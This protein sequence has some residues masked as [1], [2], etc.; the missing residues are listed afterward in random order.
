[1]R[2]SGPK[3]ISPKC[4]RGGL[5]QDLTVQFRMI[6][7]EGAG[8]LGVGVEA[9]GSA[10]VLRGRAAR[11]RAC[12]EHDRALRIPRPRASTPLDVDRLAGPWIGGGNDAVAARHQRNADSVAAAHRVHRRAAVEL[13]LVPGRRPRERVGDDHLA[14]RDVDQVTGG[15]PG[16]GVLRIK[17]ELLRLLV[18][19]SLRPRLAVVEERPQ[20][21]LVQRDQPRRKCRL[22]RREIGAPD[23]PQQLSQPLHSLSGN[24]H[25]IGNLPSLHPVVS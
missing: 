24:T 14:I 2:S 3:I 15:Q 5:V 8:V 9:D 6:A 20:H 10:R 25:R 13:N 18:K 17:A 11:I 19:P 12:H 7:Q 1:V 23:A 22:I 16:N 21:S 4:D